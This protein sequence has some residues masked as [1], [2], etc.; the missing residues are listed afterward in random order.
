M[1]FSACWG[2]SNR[3]VARRTSRNKVLRTCFMTTAAVSAVL[4]VSPSAHAFEFNT[5]SEDLKARWDNTVKYS[6]AWRLKNP[7]STLTAD[8]NQDDGNR[9]F[10]RGLISNRLDLLSEFDLL[11]KDVGFRASAAAWYDDVYNHSN[12]ND[13]PFTVNALSVGPRHFTKATEKLHGRKAELLDFFVFGKKELGD[14]LVTGRL[15]KHTL[16]YGESLFFGGNGIAVA[17]APID[18]VKALSVPNTQFKELMMP[19]QQM[20]GQLQITPRLSFGAYYQFRWEKD[21]LPGVGSYFSG[22]D[23]LGAGAERFHLG[24]PMPYLLREHSMNARNSG[25]GGMQLRYRAESHDAEYGFYAVKYHHKDPILY[26]KFGPFLPSG[27]MGTYSLVY[28]EDIKAVGASATTN[29]G[30]WNLGAEASFRSNMPLVP[31]AGGIAVGPGA[32]NH[33]NPAYPVGKTF[34]AQASLIALLHPTALWEGGTFLGEIAYNRRMS[35]TRNAAALD[36]NVTRDAMA[37]RF[38]FAP[39]YYQVIDGVDVSIPIGLGYGIFGRS[40]MINPGFSVHKGGDLSIGVSADYRKAWKF[41]LNF[42]HYFGKA[43]NF[44]TPANSPAPVES[45]KQNYKDRDFI[46]FTLQTTF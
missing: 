12:D 32:D 27:Q 25:Q 9:S 29:L 3:S 19:V 2:C 22:A 18:I 20:S 35:I 37:L 24:I 23:V 10:R 30:E 21:R 46:S 15:G 28:P 41:G 44:L 4:L 36:P 45:Y 7:S 34:H 14:M 39:S 31:R 11:Y 6:A 8:V 1:N 40:S 43:D 38:I 33:H 13:S 17:Q 5:G 16:L 42:T 26:M